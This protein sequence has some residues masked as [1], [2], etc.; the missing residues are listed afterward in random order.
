MS[1]SPS[2]FV[3]YDLMTT[4]PAAAEAFYRAVVGWN[5]KIWGE[6]G[7]YT[8]VGPGDAMV[9]G[10]MAL[11]DAVLA[12][13]GMPG[14]LGYVAVAD[15]DA[16]TAELAQAGGAVHKP[17]TD[18][19]EVGRFSVVADPQGAVFQLFTPLAG[20]NPPVVAPGTP[21][22]IG[23]H[24]L[25]AVDW[26]A[27]FDFYADRFGWTKA[28]AIDMGPMGTYQ[29]FAA[30]GV[31]IGG[32]MNKPEMIPRPFWGFY[33]NVPEIDAAAARVAENG[34]MVLMGPQEVP[35]GAWIVQ[36][37]DPQGAVF[38]LTAPTRGGGMP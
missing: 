14:W 8:L 25:Y 3:W 18:I 1:G 7:A 15:V 26:A 30:G 31:P 11:P 36:C 17:P 23:W 34:G 19:P 38:A 35:G 13:G 2:T 5:A 32:M 16:A 37:V 24:E 9:A 28:D 27:V 6:T 21:G 22:H 29:L 12:A 33:F 4:D 10:I 20:D